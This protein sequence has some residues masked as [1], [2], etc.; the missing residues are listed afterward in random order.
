MTAL[1]LARRRL[2]ASLST[3]E[4]RRLD[5]ALAAIPEADLPEGVVELEALLTRERQL[6]Y[7]VR[8][9]GEAADRGWLQPAHMEE[10]RASGDALNAAREDGRTLSSSLLC[11]ELLAEVVVGRQEDALRRA[12]AAGVEPGSMLESRRRAI[13][14]LRRGGFPD[15]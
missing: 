4:R 1:E 3:A 10:L 15:R 11:D 5:A 9:M 2:E 13:E 6:H 12:S 14:A 8:D 7:T